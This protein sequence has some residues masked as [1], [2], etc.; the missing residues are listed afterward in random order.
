MCLLKR[1]ESLKRE[2]VAGLQWLTLVI[3][4]SQEAEI[5]RIVVQG[6]PWQKA[7]EAPSQLK[8]A[9]FVAPACHLSDGEKLKAGVSWPKLAG[10]KGRPYLQNK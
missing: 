1:L 6:Q 5:G 9:G 3:L 10:Q 4:A 8:K 2:Q 7:H